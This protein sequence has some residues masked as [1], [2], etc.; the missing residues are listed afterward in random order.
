MKGPRDHALG[1]LAKAD[2]DL[3]AANATLPTGDAYDTICFHAQQAVEKCLKALLALTDIEYPRRHDLGEL[4]AL[5]KPH[6]PDLCPLEDAILELAPYAVEVRYDDEVVPDA[7]DART[8]LD[9]ATA[10]RA[11]AE[12]VL[13]SGEELPPPAAHAD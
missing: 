3:I 6:Y 4:L 8:A 9:T 11:L 7:E 5:A 13:A 12:R 10:V 1:L 2:H